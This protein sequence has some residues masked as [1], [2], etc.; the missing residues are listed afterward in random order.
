MSP[1]VSNG[2]WGGRFGNV[3]HLWLV[4]NDSSQVGWLGSNWNHYQMSPYHSSH[5]SYLT[6]LGIP[7]LTHLYFE[8][9][10]LTGDVDIGSVPTTGG[11]GTSHPLYV[12]TQRGSPALHNF[13]GCSALREVLF[14]RDG[15]R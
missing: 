12:A 6:A 13:A 9:N 2:N 5:P 4:T 3:T 8:F 1:G 10:S 15:L 11:A 14:Q 7:K